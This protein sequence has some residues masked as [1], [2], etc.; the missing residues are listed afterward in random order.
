MSELSE[1]TTDLMYLHAQLPGGGQDQ[2]AGTRRG[3]MR[4]VQKPFENREGK[5]DG[6]A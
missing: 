6:L 2:H 5:G 4:L 3:L 1:L